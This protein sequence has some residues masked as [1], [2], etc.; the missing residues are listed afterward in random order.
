M[1]IFSLRSIRSRIF[2]LLIVFS[3]ILTSFFL[4]AFYIF[5]RNIFLRMKKNEAQNFANLLAVNVA[6]FIAINDLNKIEETLEVLSKHPSLNEIKIFG[7]LGEELVNKKFNESKK[8]IWVISEIKSEDQVLGGISLSFDYPKEEKIIYVFLTLAFLSSFVFVFITILLTQRASIKVLNPLFKVINLMEDFSKKRGDLSVSIKSDSAYEID[9]LAGAFNNFKET[10]REIVLKIIKVST[11]SKDESEFINTT[12]NDFR[13]QFE[14]ITKMTQEIA[15]IIQLQSETLLTL[16]NK[17]NNMKEIFDDI[18]L[19]LEEHRKHTEILFKEVEKGKERVK[20]SEL[21]LTSMIESLKEFSKLI[22]DFKNTNEILLETSEKIEDFSQQINILALNVTI[23]SSHLKEARQFSVLSHE[24][25]E[26]SERVRKFNEDSKKRY[27]EITSHITNFISFMT[28]FR[29]NTI[30]ELNKVSETLKT[31]TEIEDKARKIHKFI[32]EINEKVIHTRE[33]V[34]ELTSSSEEISKK[35]ENIASSTEEISAGMQE[36]NT[37]SQSIKDK[38][39]EVN[40]LIYE[41]F[42]LVHTFKV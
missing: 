29:Q 38:V 15:E 5:S 9:R 14:E 37:I 6:P 39:N 24:I 20:N 8:K 17:I 32:F 34:K 41:L 31:F 26:I 16:Q 7:I 33:L 25:R 21:I 1:K 36:I 42:N 35:G 13:N 22:E 11:Q 40:T 28:E 3:I 10:I 18:I 19:K 12:F 4:S 30:S 2:F 23:E 27:R